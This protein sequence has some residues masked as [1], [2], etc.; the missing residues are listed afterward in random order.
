MSESKQKKDGGNQSFLNYH[1]FESQDS[2]KPRLIH[3]GIAK[4][5]LHCRLK[6]Y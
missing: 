1:L 4:L 5:Q 2:Q 6:L 3:T